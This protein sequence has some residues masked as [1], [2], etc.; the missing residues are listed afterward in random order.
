MAGLVGVG[1]GLRVRADGALEV[2][3]IVPLGPVARCAQVS[4]HTHTHTHTQKAVNG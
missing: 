2:T 4:V 3:E 1:M